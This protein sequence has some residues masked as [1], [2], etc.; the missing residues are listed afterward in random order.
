MFSQESTSTGIEPHCP[1]CGNAEVDTF[2]K[3]TK[4]LYL[5]CPF[6]MLVFVPAGYW[7]NRES[8]KAVYDLHQNDVT[9]PGY[10]RFLSRLS[11]PLVKRLAA[12]QKGLDFGCGPT[13][14]LSVMLEEHGHQM[15]LYDPFYAPETSVLNKTYDFICATEVVEHLYTPERDFT[16]LFKLLKPGGWLGIMT[17]LVHD[18]DAFSQWHY[19]RDMTHVCFYSRET[20]CYLAQRFD[21]QVLFIDKDVILFNTR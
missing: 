7:L 14:A 11:V 12:R 10:R 19:I 5:R 21:A 13:P 4:R 17:K 6:C 9:D 20:F 3:D 8:E 15:S 16:L 1:L 2:F 18:V